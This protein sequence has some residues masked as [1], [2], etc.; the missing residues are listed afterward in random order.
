[1]EK[2]KSACRSYSTFNV[3]MSLHYS[4]KLRTKLLALKS[5]I[6]VGAEILGPNGGQI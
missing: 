1:M 4:T 3:H 6:L 2:N 5:E